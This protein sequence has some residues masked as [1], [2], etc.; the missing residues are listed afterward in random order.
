MEGARLTRWQQVLVQ[1]VLPILVFGIVL[2]IGLV[3]LLL[4]LDGKSVSDA[5]NGSEL[6]LA[7]G[8]SAFTGSLVLLG[9]RPDKAIGATISC[10]FVSALVVLPCYLAW[11]YISTAQVRH[12]DY[13]AHKAIQGGLIATAVGLLL[14]SVLV[15]YA[16]F[17]PTPAASASSAN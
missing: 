9:A 13:S 6:F 5:V 17:A 3:A 12:A 7:G 8:N 16:F 11:A 4:W 14:A 2:P 15:W 10:V 1:A